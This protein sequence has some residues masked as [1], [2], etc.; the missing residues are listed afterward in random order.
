[1]TGRHT[2]KV[3]RRHIESGNY[4]DTITISKTVSILEP[5]YPFHMFL[6][7]NRRSLIRQELK[8]GATMYSGI[9]QY[10]LI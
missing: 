10:E 8:N 7:A 5:Y 4:I 2:R 1:M 6:D 9:Y 3:E